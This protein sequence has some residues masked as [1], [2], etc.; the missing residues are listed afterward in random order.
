MNQK[1]E[2]QLQLRNLGLQTP[3]NA[4]TGMDNGVYHLIDTGWPDQFNK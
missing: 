4:A 2:E 1:I 3:A